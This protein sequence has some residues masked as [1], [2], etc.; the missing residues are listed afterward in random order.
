MAAQIASKMMSEFDTNKDGVISKQEFV[1]AL[2]AKG[3]SADDAGKQFDAID[4]K[5]A[6]TI[7]KAD[8]ESALKSGALKPP[9]RGQ[10]AAHGNA[11]AESKSAGGSGT[12][13]A[14]Y[15]PADTNRDG[16]VSAAEA[17]IYS[18]SHSSD[19]T[20]TSTASTPLGSNLDRTA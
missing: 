13:Q 2:Q 5:H 10:T 8:I 7:S 19:G 14:D 9:P 3:I 15:D 20:S 18:F 1:T 16:T 12:S 17:L 11:V 6:G 4:K